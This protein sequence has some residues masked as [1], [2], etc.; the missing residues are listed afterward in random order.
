MPLW[1]GAEGSHAKDTLLRVGRKALQP[2]LPFCSGL[3]GE[4]QCSAWL[5]LLYFLHVNTSLVSGLGMTIT[6]HCIGLATLEAHSMGSNPNLII[7]WLRG[8]GQVISLDYLQK[9]FAS[10]LQGTHKVVM[11]NYYV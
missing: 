1:K 9:I 3:C 10:V 8:L 2:S 4:T 11:R 5:T 6:C 7:Y